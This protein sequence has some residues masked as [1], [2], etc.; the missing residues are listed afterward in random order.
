M[1]LKTESTRMKPAHFDLCDI[2]SD[3]MGIVNDAGGQSGPIRE[4]EAK[5]WHLNPAIIT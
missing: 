3:N 5:A 2:G 1:K 4:I